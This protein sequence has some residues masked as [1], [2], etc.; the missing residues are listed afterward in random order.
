SPAGALAVSL[1]ETDGDLVTLGFRLEGPVGDD[2]ET[3]GQADGLRQ[4][5]LALGEERGETGQGAVVGV[6]RLGVQAPAGQ[7]HGRA[8]DTALLVG[9][10][11]V[12]THRQPVLP[13]ARLG[14]RHGPDLCPTAGDDLAALLV[15]LDRFHRSFCRR[16][17]RTWGGTS[18]GTARALGWWLR[19]P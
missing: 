16:A 4:L 17:Q 3:I 18:P 15:D 10:G 2:G 12:G 8:V 19:L 7:P 5:Q 14:R 1:G 9:D 13:L 6:G 11:V